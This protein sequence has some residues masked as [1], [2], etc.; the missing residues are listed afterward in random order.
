MKLLDLPVEVTPVLG[1]WW[2][3]NP[4]F[5]DELTQFLE[6]KRVLEIF[7]G[8]G[9][10]AALLAA[11]G[12]DIVA[13]S[14]RSSHDCHEHGFYYPV[15][16]MEAPAAVATMDGGRDVLLVC[17]PVVT[18][19][20]LVAAAIWGFDRDIVFIGEMTDYAKGHFAG[21]ASDAFFA[22]IE[23]THRFETY[24]GNMQ[25]HAVVCRL[26]QTQV[27]KVLPLWEFPLR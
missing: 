12:I 19:A 4:E 26:K 21:C 24:L 6:G 10:L 11:R 5:V 15:E 7:A 25:E 27:Q 22:S 20:V 14:R 9:Y 8:N 2:R 23:V 18:E 13:T 16:E 3:P 1:A 17:W